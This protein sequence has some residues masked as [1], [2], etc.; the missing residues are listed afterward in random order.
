MWIL[1]EGKHSAGSIES[2][3]SAENRGYDLFIRRKRKR[4]QTSRLPWGPS[5]FYKATSLNGIP[6]AQNHS[7]PTKKNNHDL[8]SCKIATLQKSILKTGE[9]FVSAT[10]LHVKTIGNSNRCP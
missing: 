10:K 4:W 1:F 6:P 2:I 9:F 5:G 7:M 3:K 8:L